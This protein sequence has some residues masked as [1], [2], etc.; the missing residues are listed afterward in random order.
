[1][2]SATARRSIRDAVARSDK[3]KLNTKQNAGIQ[4]KNATGDIRI[5]HLQAPAP[6]PAGCTV[7]SAKLRLTQKAASTGNRTLSLRRITERW[8][9]GT[10]TWNNRPARTSTVSASATVNGAGSTGRVVEFDVTDD[11]QDFVDGVYKNWGWTL[12]SSNGNEIGFFS[13]DSVKNKPELIVKWSN[14][15]EIPTDLVPAGGAVVSTPKPRLRWSFIDLGGDTTI[16]GVHVQLHT[17]AAGWTA[18][19]GWTSPTFNSGPV[20]STKPQYNLASSSYAGLPA[21]TGMWW[22]AR[23]RDGAGLWSKWSDP[24][25]VTYQGLPSVTLNSPGATVNDTTFPWAWTTTGQAKFQLLIRDAGGNE[26]W[27]SKVI[28]SSASRAYTQPRGVVRK[29]GI[30]YQAVL[31]VWDSS[32]RQD[33]PGAPAY[34]EVT[35]T[36]TYADVG[37]TAP[38]TNLEA[39]IA[40]DL[41]QVRLTWSRSTMPDQFTIWLGDDLHAV[42]N[43]PDVHVGG[44]SYELV[45][46]DVPPRIDHALTVK[47]VVVDGADNAKSSADNP[48]VP[49][50]LDP[51]GVRL[52]D[53][54][55]G[56]MVVLLDEGQDVVESDM[57]DISE[58]FEPIESEVVVPVTSTL[59]WFEGA[60]N[61]GVLAEF[62]DLTAREQRAR[63]LRMKATPTVSKVLVWG[64]NAVPVHLSKVNVVD[65][66]PAVGERYKVSFRFVAAIPSP[67]W[68]LA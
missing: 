5:P 45:L 37:A 50:F 68:E 61:G 28:A 16:G 36:F 9:E 59:R 60:V 64:R 57:P 40:D 8:K 11:L 47:A 1:M 26:L 33:L 58:T 49:V 44:T 42:A 3:P 38:V 25:Q 27:D 39:Q 34:T 15:P 22:S 24:Q 55:T 19:N 17:N 10:L 67:E 2:G 48:V 46:F 20:D 30:S 62:G 23:H 6:C 41:S 13:S 66:N 51:I 14:R 12:E 43:G 31:R 29:P 54:D 56:E 65:D 52:V 32:S 21:G 18:N 63:L 7:T 4:V 35:R 53:T